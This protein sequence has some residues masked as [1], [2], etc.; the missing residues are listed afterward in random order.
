M[1]QPYSMMQDISFGYDTDIHF[2]TDDL[3]LCTGIDYIEREIYKILITN[4][5]DW[6]MMQNIG[7]GLNDFVGQPNTRDV[8]KSI[9]DQITDSIKLTVYPAQANIRVI[10]T[11]ETTV[12]AFIDVYVTNLQITTIPFQLDFTTGNVVVNRVD[13]YI[14]KIITANLSDNTLSLQNPINIGNV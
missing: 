5:G 9:Q 10:P 1:I 6:K 4:I 2:G 12:M 8:A 13:N 14:D 3:V 11:N 7:A